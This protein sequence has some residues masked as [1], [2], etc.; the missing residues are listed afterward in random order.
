MALNSHRAS[1]YYCWSQLLPKLLVWASWDTKLNWTS[2]NSSFPFIY[3]S[4]SHSLQVSVK[5]PLPH[6]PT[7]NHQSYHIFPGVATRAVNVSMYIEISVW[8]YLLGELNYDTL[9]NDQSTQMAVYSFPY[10]STSI[11]PTQGKEISENILKV[12]IYY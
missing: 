2:T 8:D 12:S 10:T 11:E 4:S 6:L 3:R 1:Y 7:V 9:Y 5:K